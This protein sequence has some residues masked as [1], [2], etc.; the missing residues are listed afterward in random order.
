MK[1]KDIRK[2]LFPTICEEGDLFRLPSDS[3]T[4]VFTT[5]VDRE[6]LGP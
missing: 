1:Q 5:A 4:F 2:G 3:E 6:L